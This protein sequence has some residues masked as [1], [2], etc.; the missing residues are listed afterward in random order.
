ME[1]KHVIGI[2]IGEAPSLEKA[3][4]IVENGNRCPYSGS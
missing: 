1:K 4:S 2:L 3:K